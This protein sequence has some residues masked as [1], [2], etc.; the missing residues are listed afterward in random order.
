MAE[1]TFNTADR[2][3]QVRE[4]VKTAVAAYRDML[5]IFVGGRARS[6]TAEAGEVGPQP[7]ARPCK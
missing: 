4:Q 5:D 1:V 2:E 7:I 6:A 3:A